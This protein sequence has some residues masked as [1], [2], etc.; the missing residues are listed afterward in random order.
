MHQDHIKPMKP[1]F[2]SMDKLPILC[3][4][5]KVISKGFGG[6]FPLAIGLIGAGIMQKEFLY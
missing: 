2:M 3:N 6:I 5:L 4:T 1:L